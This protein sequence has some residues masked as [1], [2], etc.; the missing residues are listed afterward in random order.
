MADVP[1][2]P[3]PQ[4]RY[5]EIAE[6]LLGRGEAA[7][8]LAA[9]PGNHRFGS[10]ALKV[11]GKIFAMLVRERFVLKLPRTR[12]ETLI[13]TG[14]G[15]T[16]DAGKGRAMKEWVTIAEGQEGSWL[17]LAR[18]AKAFALEAKIVRAPK[19]KPY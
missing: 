14:V 5:H 11:D 19:Q 2:L 9:K 7:E 18:E 15:N 8:L 4:T 10:Q 13:A 17:P 16:F 3:S 1:S 12:V 6:K